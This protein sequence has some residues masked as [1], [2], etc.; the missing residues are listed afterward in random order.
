MKKFRYLGDGLF[1][2]SSLLYCFNRWCI[3][4]HVHSLFMHDYFN[5]MLLI[6]CALPALL[7]M[8]RLLRLRT[9][10]EMP[11]LGEITLYFVVWSILFE[12]VGPHVMPRATGDPWDVLAYAAGGIIAAL[13]WHR[14]R[15]FRVWRSHEL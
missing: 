4:P 6:P 8:H 11:T 12:V 9:T 13:W 10:D 7:L 14:H 2:F 3:K 15:L 5:D 1:L